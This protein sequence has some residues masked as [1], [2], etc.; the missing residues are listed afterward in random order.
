ASV[1]DVTC[2][3]FFDA[4]VRGHVA[5]PVADHAEDVAIGAT[6][7]RTTHE[8]EWEDAVL[9]RGAIA[10]PRHAVTDGAVDHVVLVPVH[11]R[12]GVGRRGIHE[13]RHRGDGLAQ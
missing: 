7:R 13:R 3:L 2:I 4:I 1:H 8:W 6:Q 9:D 10:L 12:R 5:A 11:E